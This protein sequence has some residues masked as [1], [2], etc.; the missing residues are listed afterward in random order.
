VGLHHALTV[1]ADRRTALE[2]A[3]VALKRELAG[4]P[5][6]STKLT[7]RQSLEA[8]GALSATE[9]ERC[10]APY[11]GSSAAAPTGRRGALPSSTASARPPER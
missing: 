1:I 6:H 3:A 9:R 7:V 10:D 5:T 11:P 8:I 2:S 4:T